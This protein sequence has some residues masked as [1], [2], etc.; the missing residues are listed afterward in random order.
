MD[1][2]WDPAKR[3]TN[4]AKHGIDFPGASRVFD[5]PL[6]RIEVDPRSYG[7]EMRFRAIGSVNGTV[8][9]VCFTMR[10]EKCRIIGARRANRRERESYTLSARN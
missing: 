10:G 4:L 1:F 9:F 2:E 5:D 7:R 8:L 3:S 6:A